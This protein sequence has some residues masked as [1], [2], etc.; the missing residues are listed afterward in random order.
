[1]ADQLLS[2]S[3]PIDF[4]ISENTYLAAG[5]KKVGLK[6]I[7]YLYSKPETKEYK[8]KIINYLSESYQIQID[9][10]K[11]Y[12]TEFFFCIKTNYNKRD[13]SNM[14]KI[15][16]DALI[17]WMNCKK[18]VKDAKIDDSQ[19][20]SSSDY[21]VLLGDK[22]ETEMIIFNLY[23]SSEIREEDKLS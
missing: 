21:K 12:S 1:M 23:S 10:H 15:T 17:E 14:K 13:L 7:P 16:E 18:V 8:L 3:I 5:V 22:A 4:I 20:V 11:Y 6:S 9:P 19:F 2:V